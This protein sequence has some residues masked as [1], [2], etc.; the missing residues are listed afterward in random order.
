MTKKQL[1]LL[2]KVGF[3]VVFPLDMALSIN[4]FIRLNNRIIFQAL[5]GVFAAALTIIK[6]YLLISSK[7][8]FK[9]I[10][11]WKKDWKTMFS[12]IKEYS[13]YI[14]L[15]AV[16][17]MASLGFV[18]M[19][20]E[21]Q[22]LQVVKAQEQGS[23]IEN[24]LLDELES[25]KDQIKIVQG[26][27][28]DLG[29]DAVERSEDATSQVAALQERNREIAQEIEALRTKKNSE[30]ETENILSS[31][32]MFTLLG[33]SVGWSG[34]DTRF[35]MMIMLIILL[36]IALNLTTDPIALQIKLKNE[37]SGIDKYIDAL[38]NSGSRRL[39][40]DW[41]IAEEDNIPIETC[42]RYREMLKSITYKGKPIINTKQ[43]GSSANFSLENTKKIVKIFMKREEQ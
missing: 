33:E 43:G 8:K 10:D 18:F 6:L 19:S 15:V 16:S 9:T 42:I 34:R 26:N 36:E 22:S 13:I 30:V 12:G 37:N 2:K 29:Y 25:N 28:S 17:M 20:T 40:P 32:D 1:D 4:M 11:N 21:E 5:W 38:F 35:R 24:Q 39:K 41:R 23:F 27:A 7:T 3:Y 31:S 14:G